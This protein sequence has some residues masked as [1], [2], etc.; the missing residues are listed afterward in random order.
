MG[1]VPTLDDFGFNSHELLVEVGKETMAK[2]IAAEKTIA[3]LREERLKLDRRIHNQRVALRQ[4]W[5]I[6]ETRAQYAKAWYRSPLMMRLLQRAVR[7]DAQRR[8]A[9]VESEQRNG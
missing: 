1:E 7:S 3:K 2:L 5:M 6:I 8:G 9:D 4:N